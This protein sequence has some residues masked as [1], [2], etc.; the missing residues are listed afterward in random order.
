MLIKLS[1]ALEV[2]VDTLVSEEEFEESF[3][4]Q[5]ANETVLVQKLVDSV[6][7]KREYDTIRIVQ[8]LHPTRENLMHIFESILQPVMVRIGEMWEQGSISVYDEHYATSIVGKVVDIL[9]VYALEVPKTDRKAVCMTVSSDSHV[10]G[11]KMI[12]VFLELK[13]IRSIYVD[14][15]I[16]TA[17]IISM[18]LN[19]KPDMFLI[20]LTIG[21]HLDSVKNMIGVIRQNDKLKG[22]PIVVGGQGIMTGEGIINIPGV[23]GYCKN[24]YDL[25]QWLNLHGFIDAA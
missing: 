17:S 3:D 21:R 6:L 10:L 15:N 14:N 16:S 25:D 7:E 24:T 1:E 22:L 11:I 13:G 23:Q 18:L 5:R 19:E 8:S 4:L 20:S 9:S 2:S 12:T